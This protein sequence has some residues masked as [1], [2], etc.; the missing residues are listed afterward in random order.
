ML[1][2]EPMHIIN[3]YTFIQSHLYI[4]TFIHLAI[5]GFTLGNNSALMI[6][7]NVKKMPLLPCEVDEMK[8]IFFW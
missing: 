5:R 4:H 3:L 2:C 6:D 7:L 8:T 1:I